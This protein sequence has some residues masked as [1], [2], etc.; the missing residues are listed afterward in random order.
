[1]AS[2]RHAQ[3]MDEALREF[4]TAGYDQAS[5]NRI[6]RQCGISKSSLYHYYRDKADLFETLV[7][8]RATALGAALR[9]PEP[10]SLSGA[11]MWEVFAGI[12]QRMLA[13][14]AEHPEFVMF[15]RLLYQPDIPSGEGSAVREV[16]DAVSHWLGAVLHHGQDE[17]V[18]RRDLPLSLLEELTF[19]VLQAMDRWSV[20]HID[21]VTGEDGKRM[22]KMQ[23]AVIRRLLEVVDDDRPHA[24]VTPCG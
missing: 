21:L 23:L 5:L 22:V 12:M 15:G 16:R 24:A 6:L 10:A 20:R 9:V 11:G 3:L 17:G 13:F 7:R 4:A 14:S 19:A 18:I 2:K 1:M 8:E